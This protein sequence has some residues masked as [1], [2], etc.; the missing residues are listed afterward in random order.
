MSKIENTVQVI[1]KAKKQ[2]ILNYIINEIESDPNKFNKMVKYV[3]GLT[4]AKNVSPHI[5][6]LLHDLIKYTQITHEQMEE[7][8]KGAYIIIKN[9]TGIFYKKYKKFNYMMA[10]QEDRTSSHYSYHK[11][12]PRI[13]KGS[14]HSISFDKEND[15][16]DLIMGTIENKRFNK[17]AKDNHA[18]ST[19]FQFEQSR[20][21]RSISHAISTIRYGSSIAK[22]IVQGTPITNIGALGKSNYSEFN[23]LIIN[24]CRKPKVLS[25]KFRKLIECCRYKESKKTV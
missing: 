1:S 23:P 13:G 3:T 8:L 4:F 12:Q 17:R 11:M 9:D 14:I 10:S 15:N 2:N 20:K 6:D 7:V 25:K 19:W 21:P 5:L 22:H 18:F 16:F 24:L